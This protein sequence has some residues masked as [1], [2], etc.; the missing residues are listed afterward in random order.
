[1]EA[2][3]IAVFCIELSCVII[4]FLPC[5]ISS[6]RSLLWFHKLEAKFEK[7]DNT[8]PENKMGKSK[9]FNSLRDIKKRD[10]AN[11][12]NGEIMEAGVLHN[13]KISTV[14]LQHIF[15]FNLRAPK[16]HFFKQFLYCL[17]FF[18]SLTILFLCLHIKSP[19]CSCPEGQILLRMQTL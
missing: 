18:L 19:V 5:A 12:G 6:F 3:N 9:M 7:S 8:I 10:I 4:V 14:F 2:I 15:D 1:M 11:N 13:F 16:N 17:L